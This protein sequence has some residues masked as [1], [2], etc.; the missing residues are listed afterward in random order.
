M[1]DTTYN[2]IVTGEYLDGAE[3]AATHAA[4]ARLSKVSPEQAAQV[5]AHA[6]RVVKRRVDEATAKKFQRALEKANIGV[7]LQRIDTPAAEDIHSIL[8]P[9]ERADDR[10]EAPPG[11]IYRPNNPRGFHFSIE[12]RPDFAFLNVQISSG[13]TLKIEASSMASM[14]THIAMKTKMKGGFGRLLTGENLFINEF[15][16]SHAPGEVGIAPG[17]PGDVLHCYLEGGETL[18][19]QNSAFLACSPSLTIETK[20]DIFKGIF[21]GAGLVLIKCVGE[22]DLWFNTYGAAI[23]IDVDGEYVVDTDKI[24]AFSAELDYKI[25]SVGGYK[26]FFFSGEGFVCRFTGRGKVWVQTRSEKALTA[27]AHWFRPVTGRA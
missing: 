1:S 8:Q 14:D 12:G 24:V 21:S 15:T 7:R 26:S 13:E 10:G 16:A 11:S 19:L 18:F 9:D 6:P 25:K 2:I 22:G 4:F 17:V 5:F 23:E 20:L 3:P 27:W